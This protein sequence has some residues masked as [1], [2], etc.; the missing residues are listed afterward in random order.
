[1]R[2]RCQVIIRNTGVRCPNRATIRL[3]PKRPWVFWVCSKHKEPMSA[4][5]YNWG[6]Y[7]TGDAHTPPH[8]EILTAGLTLDHAMSQADKAHYN[9]LIDSWTASLPQLLGPLNPLVGQGGQEAAQDL[10]NFRALPVG[11]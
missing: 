7:I 4:Y 2:R 5:T 11:T 9:A 10:L 8:P 3:G 1:M 6:A